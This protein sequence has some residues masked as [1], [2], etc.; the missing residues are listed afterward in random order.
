MSNRTDT[1]F[2]KKLQ[3]KSKETKEYQQIGNNFYLF[4]FVFKDF[5]YIKYKYKMA[6]IVTQTG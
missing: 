1:R 3:K 4:F 5:F 6:L 2:L